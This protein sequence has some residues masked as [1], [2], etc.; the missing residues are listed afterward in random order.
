MAKIKSIYDNPYKYACECDV[1][2][3][4]AR[5]VC[6]K[7]RRF[8]K[9]VHRARKC[10]EC[11]TRGLKYECGCWEEGIGDSIYC[12][13]CGE[14]FGVEELENGYYLAVGIDFDMVLYLSLSYTFE[15]RMRE[16]KEKYDINTIEEWHKTAWKWI[17][18]N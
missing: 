7:Q 3:E 11:N 5:I 17:R 2:I 8:N 4:L 9:L 1:P 13:N 6:K 16:R 18:G 14:A 12:D 15:E 10:P